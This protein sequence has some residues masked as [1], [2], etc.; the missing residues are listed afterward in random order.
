[1]TAVLAIDPGKLNL[2]WSVFSYGKFAGC[3]V[4]RVGKDTDFAQ[5][6]INNLDWC[7]PVD[8]V[9]VEEMQIV[10]GWTKRADDIL[11]I[12]GIA[13]RVA[14]YFRCEVVYVKPNTW[15]GTCPKHIGF[16]RIE[17]A[18]ELDELASYEDCLNAMPK[19]IREHAK[20]AVGIGLYGVDR[21]IKKIGH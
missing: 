11:T 7:S 13:D 5:G 16:L 3:G 6:H 10:K 4:S 20:D 12:K 19:S 9:V 2:G 18:L 15:R 21:S 8:K 1:M 17:K 14:G